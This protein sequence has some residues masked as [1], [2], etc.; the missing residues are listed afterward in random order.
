MWLTVLVH[1]RLFLSEN[2]HH[3]KYRSNTPSDSVEEHYK[4][5]V[6]IPLPDN[7][8]AQMDQ[9]FN[10]EDRH[11]RGLLSLVPFLFLNSSVNPD[12]YSTSMICL[13]GRKTSNTVNPLEVK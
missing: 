8:S 5:T 4:R 13:N 6:A 3:E 1:L 2:S 12:E 10:G 11:A 7:I 9:K